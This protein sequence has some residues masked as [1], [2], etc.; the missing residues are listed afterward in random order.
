MLVVGVAAGAHGARAILT[1]SGSPH[2]APVASRTIRR[3]RGESLVSTIS[4]G[5]SALH[6]VASKL[7]VPVRRSAIAYRLIEDADAITAHHDPRTSALVHETAAQ[8]RY[9]RFTGT[10]PKHG[11]TVLCDM[12]ST[13]MTVSVVD[14]AE[15]ATIT[16]T[17]TA[18]FCGDDLDHLVRRHLAANGVRTDV[19]SSRSMKERL[20]AGGV[21]TAHDIEGSR[22][23]VFTRKDFQDII[24]GS[25]RYATMVV[26]QTIEVSG[27]TPT[28]IVLLGGGANVSSIGASFERHIKL[29]THVPER[30]EL[31]SAR[32]AALLSVDQQG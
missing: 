19:D 21:V 31:V 22:H 3:R 25:V 6:A 5:V 2:R 17:R 30:P 8:L 12:G 16:S 18:T 14:L 10:V 13:G 15:G 1:Y 28:S 29:R 23:H 24:A 7:S 27:V 20:S 4:D 9:L 26:D 32:G 11:S